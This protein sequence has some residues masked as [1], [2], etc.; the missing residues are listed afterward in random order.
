MIDKP[1]GQDFAR[2]RGR[3]AATWRDSGRSA[4]WER[5]IRWL[6]ACSCCCW[7]ERRGWCVLCRT[8]QTLRRG[9]R[10]G[11]ATD[12]YDSEGEAAGPERR[13]R[14]IA[15]SFER[16][17][18]ESVGR[19]EQ[20]PP[21]FSA[22]KIHGRPAYELARKNQLVEL[23]P[24]EVEVFEYRAD[25]DRRQRG[26]LLDRVLFGHVYSFAGARHGPEVR[27]RS[28]LGGDS[29]DGRGGIFAGTGDRAGRIGGGRRARGNLPE[30]R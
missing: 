25:G 27:L 7:D 6:P 10:F 12:T 23:K 22:K 17:A 8:A 3:G 11:F 4:T 20:M 5:W 29:A 9:F 2:C 30:L 21:I 14:W 1:Q 15:N 16:L 18:A 24:V 19:F 26:A 28:A 13:R